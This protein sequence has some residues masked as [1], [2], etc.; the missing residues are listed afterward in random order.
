MKRVARETPSPRRLKNSRGTMDGKSRAAR[1]AN[2]G[3]GALEP[4]KSAV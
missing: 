1:I 3:E 4:V 2:D